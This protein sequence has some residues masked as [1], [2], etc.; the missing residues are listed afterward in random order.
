VTI[1]P[2]RQ[3][4][5]DYL[6]RVVPGEPSVRAYRDE[7]ESMSIDL[8]RAENDEGALLAT[9]GL[10]DTNQSR[11]PEIQIFSE[12]LMDS[13]DKDPLVANVL[14]TVAFYILKNGWKIA[15]GVVFEQMLDL[16]Y[17]GHALPH[18]MFISPFQWKEGMSRVE[19]GEKRIH[20]LAGVPISEAERRFVAENPPRALERRWEEH[21]TDVL[22]WSRASAV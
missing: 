1:P 10:M 20:P 7:A 3:A 6:C 4:W 5:Y 8:F 19:L 14:S 18:V 13:R 11:N 16:Y 21:D 22:D 9:I 15:P 2:L 17:P 12:V